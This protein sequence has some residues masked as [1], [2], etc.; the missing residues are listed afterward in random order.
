MAA[1][2]VMA[3]YPSDR[4]KIISEKKEKVAMKPVQ[5]EIEESKSHEGLQQYY[6][7]KIEESQMEVADKV[8]DLR[9]LEA[10][11]NE[12]NAKVRML[13]GNLRASNNVVKALQA[14]TEDLDIDVKAL[15]Q[16][17]QK[18]AKQL[19]EQGEA[20]A[21]LKEYTEGLN[22][23]H[24]DL[25]RNVGD[26]AK[27][28]GELESVLRKFIHSCEQADNGLQTELQRLRD[29][30][31]SLETRLGNS[32]SQVISAAD[33][34]KQI[35]ATFKSLRSSLDFDGEGRHSLAAWRDYAAQTL[36]DLLVDVVRIDQALV[37]LENQTC[38]DKESTDTHCR[39]IE[40][41][42]KNTINRLD[43]L[44]GGHQMHG[45]QLKRHELMVGRLQRG[46]EALGEQSDMLHTDQQNLRIAHSDAINKQEL[47]RVALTKTQ[48]DLH[49]ATKEL[50]ST[51]KQLYNLKDGLAETN[52]SMT[53]LGG[54]Y[55][56]CTKN[57][58]G[59]TKGLQDISKSVGQGEHGLLSPKT[60]RRL[61]DIRPPSV[62]AT[63]SSRESS[64]L[65]SALAE[66]ARRLS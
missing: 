31:D 62:R 46:L 36:K 42:V 20:G 33:S 15:Q 9:R 51:G 57:I 54:R 10:Q 8:K 66:E 18:T 34:V 5:M 7:T 2:E 28:H 3:T 11:R 53:R 61:P 32:Q 22:G 64:P 30:L 52:L 60:S 41:K 26:A 65:R 37:K 14:K 47:H 29:H 16:N 1:V 40:Q 43:K 55:D 56:S 38:V 6:I 44:C 23:K 17:S 21:K 45:D 27:A 58:M 25:V 48:A 24:V 50:Q 39:E 63:R 4:N 35:E 49:H 13:S 19:Q 59:M 12:L